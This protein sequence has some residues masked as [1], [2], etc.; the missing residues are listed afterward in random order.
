MIT[1]GMVCAFASV[2]ICLFSLL[3]DPV[4]LYF[5]PNISFGNNVRIVMIVS[6]PLSENSDL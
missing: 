3:A 1:V 4:T 2:C 5:P 6:L